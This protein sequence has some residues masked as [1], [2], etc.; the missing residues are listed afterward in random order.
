MRRLTS[1]VAEPSAGRWP[2]G[3]S[4]TRP[5]GPKKAVGTRGA[6]LCK[7]RGKPTLRQNENAFLDA[8]RNR[9]AE[10]RVLRVADFELVLLLNEPEQAKESEKREGGRTRK[11]TS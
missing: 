8:R 7:G 3:G 4:L 6:R 1:L 5:E 11:H 2:L 10:L 9:L